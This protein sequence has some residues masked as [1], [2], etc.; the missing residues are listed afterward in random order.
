MSEYDVRRNPQPVIISAYDPRWVAEFTQL[1]RRIRGLVGSVASRIDHIGSTAVPGLAAKD[2]IDL[3]ITRPIS[4]R[5]ESGNGF[6]SGLWVFAS[7]G[8]LRPEP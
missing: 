6:R 7:A 8:K 4:T 3:Q 5:A 1:A 2:V